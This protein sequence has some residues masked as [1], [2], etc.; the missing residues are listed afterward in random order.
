M[1]LSGALSSCDTP[2]T[3]SARMR[4]SAAWREIP[5]QQDDTHHQ[6]PEHHAD[7]GDERGDV[8]A[9]TTV[10]TAVRASD[11]LPAGKTRWVNAS[12]VR[13]QFARGHPPRLTWPARGTSTARTQSGSAAAAC[14]AV[15]SCTWNTASPDLPIPSRRLQLAWS[16]RCLPRGRRVANAISAA[17][18]RGRRPAEGGEK[19]QPDLVSTSRSA[20]EG[21]RHLADHGERA[22]RAHAARARRRARGAD[23]SECVYAVRTS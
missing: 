9:S 22:S 1:T 17:S 23:P 8:G 11:T 10:R 19:L 15:L 3:R 14:H 12:D 20:F 7:R 6:Q 18:A 4:F 5:H 13:A 21:L 16:G 2:L